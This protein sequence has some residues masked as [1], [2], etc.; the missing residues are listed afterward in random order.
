MSFSKRNV[1]VNSS[2]TRGLRHGVSAST[3]QVASGVRSSPIDGRLTTSTGI[4]TLDELIAGHAG[5]PLGSSLMI[6]ENGST[7]FAGAL[8]RFYAAE[9]L[10]QGHQL[11]LVGVTD[12]CYKD[13]PGD[14]ETE[15]EQAMTRTSAGEPGDGRMKI[16]W[17]YE[18]L[19]EVGASTRGGSALTVLHCA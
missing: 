15:D 13:L 8:L 14:V 7:D 4:Q 1:G 9:G 19:G 10:V 12:K 5:L 2:T 3:S 16:A 17:R 18:S 11:H 6:E